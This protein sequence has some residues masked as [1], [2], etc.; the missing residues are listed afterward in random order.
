MRTSARSAL[1]TLRVALRTLAL[2]TLVLGVGY[3]LVVTALAQVLAPARAD[4]SLLERDGRVVGSALLGQ[5]FA[6]SDGNA[7]PGYFQ[8]RP[9]AA[10]EGY[11]AGASG[12]S[13]LGPENPELTARITERRVEIAAREGVAPSA[14]PADAVT[15]SGSGLDPDISPAYAALQ[16]DRVAR[17]RGLAPETVRRLVAQHTDHP[18]LGPPGVQ[19]LALNLALDEARGAEG[20]AAR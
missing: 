2:A 14:V 18:V 9:S 8:S 5:S 6:D 20:G 7:L 3:T 10:G 11:D 13:N 12:G 19:V 1:G 4:G 16:V 15:A 17:E